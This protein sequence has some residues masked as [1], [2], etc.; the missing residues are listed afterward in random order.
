MFDSI[1]AFCSARRCLQ[2]PQLFTCVLLQVFE[3][4][5]SSQRSGKLI[6]SQLKEATQ[7]H[8]VDIQGV[9]THKVSYFHCYST[10]SPTQPGSSPSK[11]APQDMSRESSCDYLASSDLTS[12]CGLSKTRYNF[13]YP[14]QKL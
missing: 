6:L 3:V 11:N 7:S 14:R 2:V 8:Q 4:N 9:N 5:S 10:S 1:T 12:G 13:I